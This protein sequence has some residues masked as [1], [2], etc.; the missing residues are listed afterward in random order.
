MKRA[1]EGATPTKD[2]NFEQNKGR[3]TKDGFFC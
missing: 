3:D 2:K 1:V